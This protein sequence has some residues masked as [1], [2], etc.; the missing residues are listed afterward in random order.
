MSLIQEALEK[1]GKLKEFY[2]IPEL[3]KT[4]I[5]MVPPALE[6]KPRAGFKFAV[7]SGKNLIKALILASGIWMIFCIWFM[8]R[9]TGAAKVAAA[10]IT[11]ISEPMPPKLVLSGI[12][13]SADGNLALI[14]GQVAGVGDRL[15]ERAFIKEIREE[16]VVLD[17]NGREITLKL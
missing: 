8:S 9:N 10:G 14:N 17:W 16:S 6:K 7:F 1:A 11:S 13:K 12:T 2:E 5:P 4:E 15:K 3:E